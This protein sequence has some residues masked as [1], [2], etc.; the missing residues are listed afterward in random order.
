[1]PKL[2]ILTRRR[3]RTGT[4]TG[5]GVAKRSK[6]LITKKVPAQFKESLKCLDFIIYLKILPKFVFQNVPS[7]SFLICLES[8]VDPDRRAL[9][10]QY[11]GLKDQPLN[12]HREPKYPKKHENH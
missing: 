6:L 4:S 5:L 1:M 9:T 8:P 12:S 3:Q 2:R 11:Y 7:G 10:S